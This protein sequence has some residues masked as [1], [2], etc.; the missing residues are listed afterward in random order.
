MVRTIAA[1]VAVFVGWEAVDFLVHGV[2]LKASYAETASLWRPEAEIKMGL[3]ALVVLIGALAFVLIYKRLARD[4]GL[5]KGLEYGFW[6]GLA[7]AVS[8]GYGTYAVMPIPYSM[9]Q[10]W[11]LASLAHG[12]L[13][14]ALAGAIV[15][16]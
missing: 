12:L 8:M 15:R 11:F 2:L 5:F 4:K 16:D 7:A 13:G 9:A 3:M 10:A 14:G 1:I 6:F